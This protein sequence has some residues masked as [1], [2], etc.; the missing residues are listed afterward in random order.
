MRA[1]L[2]FGG[3]ADD[4]QRVLAT[5]YRFALVC[6]ELLLNNP[7]RILDGKFPS[8]GDP[9]L[10]IA[11]HTYP[12]IGSRTDALNDLKFAFWH[13]YSL[14]PNACANETA[15]VPNIAI[16]LVEVQPGAIIPKQKLF[17]QIQ[18]SGEAT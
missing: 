11:S 14:A 15:Q 8:V 7:C 10:L 16:A 3:F 12:K 18:Q 1:L 9:E 2:V 6:V 5:V 4:P 17:V 13:K